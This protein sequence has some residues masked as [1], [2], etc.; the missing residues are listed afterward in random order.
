MAV[1]LEF[2]PPF[3]P[4]IF[5]FLAARAVAGVEEGSGASYARTV[6]LPGGHGW[7]RVAWDGRGLALEHDLEDPADL[8]ELVTRVRRLL[9]LD[10]DPAVTDTVLAA[11]P[12]LAS[13][14]A[15]VPG[16]RLPGCID[17]A[18]IVIRAMIGQQITVAAA[19][20][21]LTRLAALGTPSRT[22][23]G[24]MARLFPS[25]AQL[26]AGGRA[27][28][29]G[30]Q[31]RIDAVLSVA[32]LLADRTVAIDHTDTPETLAGKLLPLPGIGPWTLGYVGMRVL[33]APDVFLPTDAA[34]RNGFGALRGLSPAQSRR[35]TPADLAA[36]AEPLKPWRSY[37]TLHLWRAAAGS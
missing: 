18:E 29:R 5:A 14:V 4:G 31:R 13:R 12:Q 37:A 11:D 34:V 17:P 10:R 16:L 33:G 15:A 1:T 30:P 20:T 35:F 19:R 26:A 23:H 36:M 21:A 9:D 2:H 28:L 8:P 25:P 24:S 22:P 6:L 32:G 27:I 7:F 3:D